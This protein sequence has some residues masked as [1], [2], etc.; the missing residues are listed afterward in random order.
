MYVT[1]SQHTALGAF[2]SHYIFAAF[3][4]T[5]AAAPAPVPA[6]YQFTIE[7]EDSEAP[8]PSFDTS[9]KDVEAFEYCFGCD[10]NGYKIC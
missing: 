7:V 1:S 2:E 4:M 5:A 8:S 6:R 9:G 10:K 3:A